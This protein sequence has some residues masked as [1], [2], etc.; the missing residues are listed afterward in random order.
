[1]F[2]LIYIVWSL[3]P[4]ALGAVC[5]RAAV[6]AAINSPGRE[7]P[8]DTFTQFLFCAVLFAVSIFVDRVMF[9]PVAPFFEL[10]FFD[11]VMVRWLI[12]PS[13]LVVCASIHNHF[14]KAEEEKLKLERRKRRM[15][16]AALR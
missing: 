14:Y 4:L 3:L 9:P 12:Y 7:Y 16:Y 15:K 1:M 8:T 13:L 6:R 5:L 11:P 10:P 2:E